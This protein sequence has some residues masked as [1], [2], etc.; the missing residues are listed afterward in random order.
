MPAL[1]WSI[2]L[3]VKGLRRH[4]FARGNNHTTILDLARVRES[5][6]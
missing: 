6:N 1:I 4:G 2:V 5:L 3:G